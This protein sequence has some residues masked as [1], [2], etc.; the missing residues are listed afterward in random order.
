MS[1]VRTTN[2]QQPTTRE[3]LVE[4]APAALVQYFAHGGTL[5]MRL[6]LEAIG[7]FVMVVV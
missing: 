4:S 6:Q 1:G 5:S 2:N 7:T 3:G